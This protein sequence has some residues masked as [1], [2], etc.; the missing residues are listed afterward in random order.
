MNQKKNRTEREQRESRK[1]ELN[2]DQF[3]MTNTNTNILWAKIAKEKTGGGK[4]EKM[5]EMK[6][7]L[8]FVNIQV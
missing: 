5:E 4:E 3:S 1:F 7:A 6:K 8:F 2:C